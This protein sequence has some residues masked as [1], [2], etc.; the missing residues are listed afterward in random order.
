MYYA[1]D[2]YLV[3]VHYNNAF[4]IPRE[5]C[6]V[7][8]P[9]LAD[10]YRTGYVEKSDRKKIFHWN[11]DIEDLLELPPEQVKDRVEAMFSQHSGQYTCRL[12]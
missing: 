1:H 4:L 11:A 5:L 9:A 10:A 7:P 6:K 2:Y 12:D 8:V 3:R